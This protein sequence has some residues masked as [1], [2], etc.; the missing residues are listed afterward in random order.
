MSVYRAKKSK[1]WF[2]VCDEVGCG[3]AVL[4][5]SMSEA[6]WR[7]VWVLGLSTNPGTDRCPECYAKMSPPKTKATTTAFECQFVREIE[8][9]ADLPKTCGN[10]YYTDPPREVAMVCGCCVEKNNWEKRTPKTCETCGRDRFGQLCGLCVRY[11]AWTPKPADPPKTCGKC[12]HFFYRTENDV[13][14]GD[15]AILCDGKEACAEFKLNCDPR[16]T[17]GTCGWWCKFENSSEGWCRWVKVIIDGSE[18]RGCWK[19]RKP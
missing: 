15:C 8:K 11:G 19:P 5:G 12:E 6:G 9:F 7:K 10:C 18:L 17:C 2:R 13:T 14:T 3:N 16:K 1:K 4:L